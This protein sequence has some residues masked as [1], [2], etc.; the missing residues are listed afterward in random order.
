MSDRDK[1][2]VYDLLREAHKS[3]KLIIESGFMAE[4]GEM[5]RGIVEAVD[6]VL[7]M[8]EG[9]FARMGK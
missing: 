2:K 1:L 7:Y 8:A 5:E 6:I 4:A 9:K 3:V